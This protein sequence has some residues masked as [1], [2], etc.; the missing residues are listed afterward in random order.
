[1]IKITKK[2]FAAKSKIWSRSFTDAWCWPSES[3]VSSH[4]G[5][6][7]SWN[8]SRDRPWSRSGTKA[9]PWSLKR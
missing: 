8:W 4:R 2:T 6:A 3:S 7:W 1:M 5:Y 9:N